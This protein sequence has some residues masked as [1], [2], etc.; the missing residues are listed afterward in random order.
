MNDLFRNFS[1]LFSEYSKNF[2]VKEY[3]GTDRAQLMQQ[4]PSVGRGV[5][6]Y[7]VKG[8]K[9]PIYI[10]CSG[11]VSANGDLSGS[12]VKKRIFS[13]STPYHISRTESYLFYSPTSAGVPPDGYNSKIQLSELSIKIIMV[14]DKIAPAALEHSLLQGFINEYGCLPEANQKL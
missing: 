2:G 1:E 10:G 8:A 5:Y 3:V 4:V 11:K 7:W 12:T 9:R 6:T 14:S 13:A